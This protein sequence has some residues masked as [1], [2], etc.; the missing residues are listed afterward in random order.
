M[1]GE[2]S[3]QVQRTYE[4]SHLEGLK[5][6]SVYGAEQ[7]PRAEIV[8]SSRSSFGTV[9]KIMRLKH[10]EKT[11][12]RTLEMGETSEQAGRMSEDSQLEGLKVLPPH[13]VEQIV[14]W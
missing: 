10:L 4:G 8:L 11:I 7:H 13:D 3:D 5:V 9:S 2:A 14:A 1:I 6:L 12:P